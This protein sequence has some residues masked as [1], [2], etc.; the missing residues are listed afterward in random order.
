MTN[1]GSIGDKKSL[2]RMM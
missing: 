2:L 1:S